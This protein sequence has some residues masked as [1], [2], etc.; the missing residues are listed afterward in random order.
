M[1]PF[2]PPESYCPPSTCA[3]GWHV[4]PSKKT[5]D[6]IPYF[7]GECK[8]TRPLA[9]SSASGEASGSKNT[10]FM[11]LGALEPEHRHWSPMQTF[12]I[13]L[14]REAVGELLLTEKEDARL[15]EMD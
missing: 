4:K 10:L 13:E 8:T 11:Y 6:V 3:S 5:G 2:N 1:P 15:N 14:V 9:S 12:P 7:I